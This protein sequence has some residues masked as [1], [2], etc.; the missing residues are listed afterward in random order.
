MR[1]GSKAGSQPRWVIS[2]LIHWKFECFRALGPHLDYIQD[3]K[4]REEFH[5]NYTALKGSEPEALLGRLDT[6]DEKLG[7]L[8]GLWKPLY[9]KEV[10]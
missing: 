3:D 6:D 10:F 7:V 4:K 5:K 8:L 1:G 2:G 9:P